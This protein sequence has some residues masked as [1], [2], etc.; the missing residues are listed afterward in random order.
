MSRNYYKM[1]SKG[2]SCLDCDSAIFSEGFNKENGSFNMKIDEDGLK[3]N[4][5][6][7]KTNDAEIKI[8]KS[9]V[10]IK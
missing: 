3:I 5:N 8:D 9:G 1:T 4:V 10:S 6:E 7:G 2:L